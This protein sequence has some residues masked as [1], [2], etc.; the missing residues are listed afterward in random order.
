MGNLTAK[1][2]LK[3]PKQFVNWFEIP[4]LDL[5]RAV[6]F[7]NHLYG[8]EMQVVEQG[9]YAMA[10][11]PGDSKIGGA[12]V[13]G[14]GCTPTESGSL[15]YLNATEDID[16]MLPRVIEMGGRV[17]LEKTEIIHNAGHFAL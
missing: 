1:R 17:I 15:L 5:E 9:D 13:K 7:Y 8:M 6:A 4:V 2:K 11:F 14:Q 3:T 12:L 16:T 10:L